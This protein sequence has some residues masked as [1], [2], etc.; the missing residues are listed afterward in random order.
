MKQL[1]LW[2]LAVMA[3]MAAMPA[4]AKT[5]TVSEIYMFG[6]S[7]SF[8]DSVVFVT[9]IQHVSPVRLASK[10]QFLMDRDQYSYQL[11]NYL[12]DTLQRPGRIC[13]VIFDTV[14]KKAEKK[15]MKLMKKYKKG[16]DI[17]YLNETQ[18]RF[19]AI[20]GDDSE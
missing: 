18:F 4:E 20:P 11:K 15:Y 8:K 5:D 2:L 7:A 10:T 16:Y 12:T 1:K 9:D 14:K 3:V 13:L 17:Q 6:F 19:Q